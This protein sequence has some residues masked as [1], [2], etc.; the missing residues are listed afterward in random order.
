MQ[1]KS[2]PCWQ[3]HIRR[4]KIYVKLDILFNLDRN[5]GTEVIRD[6]RRDFP[7]LVTISRFYVVCLCSGL[8]ENMKKYQNL[9]AH[10]MHY[11]THKHA[12]AHTHVQREED[13]TSNMGIWYV[14]L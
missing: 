1:M 9:R 14:L 6:N 3:S 10:N 13:H 12:R 4:N 5:E 11:N 7:Q 8:F 2:N